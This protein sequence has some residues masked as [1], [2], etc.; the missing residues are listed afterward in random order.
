MAEHVVSVS[1]GKDSTA[2][3]C[4]VSEGGYSGPWRQIP[5]TSTPQPTKLLIALPSAPAVQS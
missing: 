3:Y 2:T 1:G 5:A 4:L